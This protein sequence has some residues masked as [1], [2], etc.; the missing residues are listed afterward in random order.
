MPRPT[1][2]K[3]TY[4]LKTM[5]VC[6]TQH[7]EDDIYIHMVKMHDHIQELYEKYKAKYDKIMNE[8]LGIDNN[9]YRNYN[10]RLGEPSRFWK[11]NADY[12]YLIDVPEQDRE[13][14]QAEWFQ[15]YQIWADFVICDRKEGHEVFSEKEDWNDMVYN[16]GKIHA[17]MKDTYDTIALYE[18]MA[19]QDAKREWKQ[20]DKDWIQEQEAKKD[21]KKHP[22]IQLPSTL[23][24]DIK[25]E[26]YPEQP[27]R[28]DCIYCKRHW[29]E[30]KP[31]YETAVQLWNEHKQEQIEWEMKNKLEEEKRRKEREER[32]KEYELRLASL[33]PVNLHCEHCDFTAEDDDEL[34]NH[35]ESDEHKEKLRF[36]KYCKVQCPSEYAYKNHLETTKHKKNAGLIDNKPKVYKCSKCEYETITK[37]NFERHCFLLHAFQLIEVVHYLILVLEF[38]HPPSHIPSEVKVA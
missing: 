17:F 6:I 26:P 32:A 2:D 5:D 23:F 30:M 34:D 4:K 38:S 13:R 18:D 1:L 8:E 15:I 29:E 14:I 9:C 33:P 21:H 19:Y 27:L 11:K 31:R 36:C 20:K 37:A 12:W 16:A 10:W 22:V 7:T 25:P 35:N 3:W 28:Q 24:L